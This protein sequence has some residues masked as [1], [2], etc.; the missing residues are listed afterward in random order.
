[1]FSFLV[2][3][4][5]L[6]EQ[7]RSKVAKKSAGI[8][9]KRNQ[10]LQQIRNETGIEDSSADKESDHKR[11][12][13]SNVRILTLYALTALVSF[14]EWVP[15]ILVVIL[16]VLI[17]I[18]LIAV[19]LAVLTFVATFS[20]VSDSSRDFSDSGG[21]YVS[22]SP[23]Q[24]AWTDEELTAAGAAFTPNERNIYRMGIALRKAIEGYGGSV[25]FSEGGDIDT[26]VRM[27]LGIGS[28]ENSGGLT[29]FGGADKS[30]V[31]YPTGQTVNSSGYGFWGLN[32]S[33]GL[34]F[35]WK[36]ATQLAA[37]KS[38]YQP[39]TA[40]RVTIDY[41]PY[42]AAMSVKH[43]QADFSSYLQRDTTIALVNQHMDTWGIQA[44][45]EKV[46]LQVRMMLTQAHY[47]GAEVKEYPYYIDFLLAAY[48]ATS[49]NDAERS[50]S[51]WVMTSATNDTSES[52]MRKNIMG[53]TKFADLDTLSTPDQMQKASSSSQLL[54]NGQ[55]LDKP[56]W[57]FL[58]SK[59]SDKPG[60]QASWQQAR[61]FAAM[62]AATPGTGKQ[63]RVLNFHYGFNS[64]VQAN[65][66]VDRMAAK[67]S[68]P[69]TSSISVANRPA[70]GK[71]QETPGKGQAVINGMSTEDYIKGW[72]AGLGSAT[73]AW[74]DMVRPTWGTSSYLKGKG[75]AISA[76]YKDLEFGVPFYG[77]SSGYQ[78]EYNSM[79]YAPNG[80][81]SFGKLA[82]MVFSTAYGVSALTGNMVNTPE[83]S[84]L[85][86]KDGLLPN[87]MA[88][89]SMPAWITKSF[90]LKSE[91]VE[92]ITA[93]GS[94]E[95]M[96]AEVKQGGIAVVRVTASR[97]DTKFTKN[98]HFMVINGVTEKNGKEYYNIYTSSMVDKSMQVYTKEQLMT[99]LWRNAFSMR[100]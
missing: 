57:A 8:K 37:I 68:K 3:I 21:G 54:L 100:K 64:L 22:S 27:A 31:D 90:G 99:T 24:L 82:C 16:I 20:A 18:C 1:M 19:V 59:Y 91:Y 5:T 26:S 38:A 43:L 51:K 45:R 67:I 33:R 47:H 12:R 15:V 44:N 63:A 56:L 2:S 50:Y 10:L 72:Y 34:D 73:K 86:Y 48:V 74:V 94:F 35:Y 32:A 77:Q 65:S 88:V 66:I 89:G 79:Q 87:G 9:A 41:A 49:D 11:S 23:G 4:L 71:F 36:D 62:Y 17:V 85:L 69:S 96:I 25:N 7:V 70:P 95:K 81:G 61:T 98:A 39:V 40:P 97:G 30:I 28:T 84:T 42:A 80:S 53:S 58:W 6:Y 83:M 55:E 93:S 78:E 29:F 60:F 75:A 46:S 92:N 76:G 52:S 13:M 14:F